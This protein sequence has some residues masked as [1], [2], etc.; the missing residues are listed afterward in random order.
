MKIIY[1]T[2]GVL[3]RV[4]DVPSVPVELRE[5][6]HKKLCDQF[7]NREVVKIEIFPKKGVKHGHYKSIKELMQDSKKAL[8]SLE[9]TLKPE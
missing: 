5:E 2:E 6:L 9:F 3:L 7:D 1:K 8:E 4:V